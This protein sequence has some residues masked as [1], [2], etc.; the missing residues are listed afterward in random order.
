MYMTIIFQVNTLHS[1][2]RCVPFSFLCLSEGSH[3]SLDGN[4][5][6]WLR[7][8][9]LKKLSDLQSD[10]RVTKG[11]YLKLVQVGP[12]DWRWRRWT[13]RHGQWARKFWWGFRWG[14]W[15][16]SCVTKHLNYFWTFVY[17]CIFCELM[18]IYVLEHF[19]RV[20]VW[21]FVSHDKVLKSWQ[22]LFCG[23]G[24]YIIYY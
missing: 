1:W 12:Q 2:Y 4:S 3:Q 6:P 9:L 7:C 16:M 17:I 5:V 18:T 23:C 21:F 8:I 14:L 15:M 24:Y 11:C 13:R 10:L 22:L 19:I 20:T